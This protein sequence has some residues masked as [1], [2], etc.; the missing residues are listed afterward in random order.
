MDDVP[1]GKERQ[2]Y[3]TAITD[4]LNK[5]NDLELLDLISKLLQKNY[6]RRLRE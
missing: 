1:E 5:C 3:I 2:A 6:L 4:L